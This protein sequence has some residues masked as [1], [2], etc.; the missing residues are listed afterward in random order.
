M[1]FT[2]EPK[3]EACLKSVEKQPLA[4]VR[5]TKQLPCWIQIFQDFKPFKRF[6]YFKPDAMTPHVCLAPRKMVNETKNKL[7]G[8]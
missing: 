5:I 4:S 7:W 8:P 3:L 2:E 1:R 6:K